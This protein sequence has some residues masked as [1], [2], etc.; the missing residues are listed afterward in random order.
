MRE[1]SSAQLMRIA[2]RRLSASDMAHG[3]KVR[4]D[5]CRGFAPVAETSLV[6]HG[7]IVSSCLV[8]LHPATVDEA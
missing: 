6:N 5:R 8:M 1:I 4:S 3:K 2:C 7:H